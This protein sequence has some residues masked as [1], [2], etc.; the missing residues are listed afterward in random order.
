MSHGS[1]AIDQSVSLNRTVCRKQSVAFSLSQLVYSYY[2]QANAH[3]VHVWSCELRAQSTL[4]FQVEGLNLQTT[5]VSIRVRIVRMQMQ[6]PRPNGFC[7]R[8]YPH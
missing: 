7:W 5:K 6:L 1:V 2:T 4:K 3:L 8:S